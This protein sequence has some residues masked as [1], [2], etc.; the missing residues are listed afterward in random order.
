MILSFDNELEKMIKSYNQ[1]IRY[2]VRPILFSDTILSFNLGLEQGGS[3][4]QQGG[5]RN[6][7]RRCFGTLPKCIFFFGTILSH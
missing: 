7:S 3:G 5:T 4:C 6:L 1:G 2:V